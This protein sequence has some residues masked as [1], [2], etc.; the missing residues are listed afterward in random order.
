MQPLAGLEDL[1]DHRPHA[2][3]IVVAEL[4]GHADVVVHLAKEEGGRRWPSGKLK[5]G[6]PSTRG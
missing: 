2:K 3:R 1:R 4:L 6:P 5:D